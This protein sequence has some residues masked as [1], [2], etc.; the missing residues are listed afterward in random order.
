MNAIDTREPEKQKARGRQ[1]LHGWHE[2]HEF[3]GLHG[4]HEGTRGQVW[5]FLP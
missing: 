5:R 4:L 1:S 2:L 3:H